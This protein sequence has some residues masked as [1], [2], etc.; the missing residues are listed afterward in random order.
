MLSRFKEGII[1]G[2]YNFGMDTLLSLFTSISMDT[3]NTTILCQDTPI[4]ILPLHISSY[5]SL[6]IDGAQS[7][8]EPP[9]PD[10]FWYNCSL[11]LSMTVAILPSPHF[12]P[13]DETLH[14]PP[15]LVEA[16]VYTSLGFQNA[17]VLL[18]QL[19]HDICQQEHMNVI[20]SPNND[21]NTQDDN[22]PI[23]LD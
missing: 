18:H 23:A 20:A 12:C 2:Y 13:L 10:N 3:N 14:M 17:E 8:F 15:T 1:Y 7:T 4:P 19:I 5:A 21:D 11:S 16:N 9:T 6:L 22:P